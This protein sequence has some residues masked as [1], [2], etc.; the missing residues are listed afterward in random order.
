MLWAARGPRALSSKQNLLRARLLHARC[1]DGSLGAVWRTGLVGSTSRKNP[2]WLERP[3]QGR[4]L[5]VARSARKQSAEH[6]ANSHGLRPTQSTHCRAGAVAG[7]VNVELGPESPGS[8]VPP[9]R[10]PAA[11]ATAPQHARGGGVQRPNQRNRPAKASRGRAP[12]TRGE[13]K[14]SPGAPTQASPKL[15]TSLCAR[16]RAQNTNSRAPATHRT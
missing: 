7:R 6:T 2:L 9:R 15:F 13:S 1:V 16:K 8:A 12:G 4:R 10:A 11:D 14:I 3:P 5:H